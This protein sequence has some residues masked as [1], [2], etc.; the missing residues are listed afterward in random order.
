MNHARHTRIALL[1]PGELAAAL[2]AN[3]PDAFRGMLSEDMQELGVP[4]VE[5]LLLNW[6][7]SFLT[8][9]EQ[10]RLLG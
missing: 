7:Y 10:D 8:A 5:E 4:D 9:E 3:D 6:H 2:C 1:L